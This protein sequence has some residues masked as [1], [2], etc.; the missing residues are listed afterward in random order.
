MA[1]IAVA[2]DNDS[3]QKTATESSDLILRNPQYGLDI[4]NMLANA[5]PAQQIY[6]ATVLAEVKDNWTA[7]QRDKYF[8][9]FPP[10]LASKGGNSFTGYINL[11]RK[12]ALTNA[13]KAQYAYYDS[14]SGNSL[15]NGSG[16]IWQKMRSGKRP[17]KR[18]DSEMHLSLKII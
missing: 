7:A 4:A 17:G 18:L 2:K 8:A 5:P 1:L 9:L 13:P 12:M 16:N 3:T 10:I 15:L 6:L 14:I 11:A